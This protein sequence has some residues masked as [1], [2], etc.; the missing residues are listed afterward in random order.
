M[1][2]RTDR[3]YAVGGLPG[4]TVISNITEDGEHVDVYD[5]GNEEEWHADNLFKPQ[6]TRA[7]LPPRSH[8]TRRPAP[9]AR[10]GAR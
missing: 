7:T 4:L 6:L 2:T 1:D 8:R 5:G 9:R 10:R 3:R